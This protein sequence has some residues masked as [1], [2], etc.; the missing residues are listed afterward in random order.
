MNRTGRRWWMR[1]SAADDGVAVGTGIDA[2]GADDTSLPA[3][4]RPPKLVDR[5]WGLREI[6]FAEGVTQSRMLR[7]APHRLLVPYTRTML[8]AL[9]LR[10]DPRRI[11]IIGLG[12]G[13]QVKWCHRHLPR[14][15]I[16]VVEINRHVI[17]MR[18]RFRIPDDDARLQVIE[19]DGAQFLQE[20]P[21][22]YDLLLVDG[23][24]ECG[25]PE[26]LASQRFHDSCR[27]ALAAGGVMAS[28]LYAPDLRP[29]LAR[30]RNSFAGRWLCLPE[31]RM[32]NQVALAWDAQLQWPQPV[33]PRRA[34]AGLSVRGWRELRD[35]FERVAQ[36]LNAQALEPSSQPE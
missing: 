15:R 12:G 4:L 36:V 13:S 25:I 9:L 28:N 31:P 17:A 11:G 27:D 29:H 19:G 18:R 23:Y 10:P 16:E 2:D 21:A 30:L 14:A 20:R 32:R 22:R 34:K 1:G 7:L 26:A 35:V 8:G 5:G 24:D 6:G 33:D 3:A